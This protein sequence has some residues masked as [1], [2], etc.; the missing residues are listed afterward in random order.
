MEAQL[1]LLYDMTKELAETEESVSYERFEQLIE[2][3]ERVIESLNQ[4]KELSNDENR[5]IKLI[6]QLDASIHDR[7]CVIR[8]EASKEL[9]L[10]NA[11][12]IQRSGYD[13]SRYGDSYFID[14][15]N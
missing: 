4:H 15:R 1:K 13:A 5:L 12:R 9:R 14:Y 2:L 7:M 8:D 11:S 3:R 10:I 6:V